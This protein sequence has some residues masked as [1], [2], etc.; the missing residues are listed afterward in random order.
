MKKLFL[1]R[2][3]K[4]SW[5]D[6]TLSDH[7]RPLNERGIRNANFMAK[8]LKEKNIFPDLIISSTA[9]RARQTANIFSDILSH[10][11]KI[12]YD[13]RIY[14]A[15]TQNLI[16][17]VSEIENINNLVFLF[18]HNPG[19]SNFANFI[20]N[21]PIYNL[22]TCA[23]VGLEI[24]IDNWENISRNSGKLIFNEYPKKYK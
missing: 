20:S 18:G 15:T 19:L 16:E 7:E 6:P 24:P 1:I 22:P 14:E 4:S 2:H 12:K 11:K 10:T 17:V 21:H 8:L 23:I 13:S 3:A 9:E 5:D